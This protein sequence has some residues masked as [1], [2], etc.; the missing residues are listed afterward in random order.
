MGKSCGER[1]VSV[2]ALLKGINRLVDILSDKLVHTI[3][4]P[5]FNYGT[6]TCI[7]TDGTRWHLLCAASETVEGLPCFPALVGVLDDV[8]ISHCSLCLLWTLGSFVALELASCTEAA[9]MYSSC[10]L[11]LMSHDGIRHGQHL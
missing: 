10:M 8:D 2:G 6:V 1:S 11:A 3:V 5:I 7:C 9:V 4:A